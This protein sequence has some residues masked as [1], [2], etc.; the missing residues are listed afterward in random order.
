MCGTRCTTHDVRR[1]LSAVRE[2]EESSVLGRYA[3][4]TQAEPRRLRRPR[5]PAHSLARLQVR[6]W[7]KLKSSSREEN[8]RVPLVCDDADNPYEAVKMP[9]EAATWRSR[10]IRQAILSRGG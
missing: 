3:G 9:I 2:A 10:G 1:R 6:G 4:R 7:R 8:G 5:L